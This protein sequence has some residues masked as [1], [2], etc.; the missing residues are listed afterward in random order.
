MTRRPL[1]VA[2]ALKLQPVQ[3][4]H[5]VVMPNRKKQAV[6]HVSKP[7]VKTSLEVRRT[8]FPKKQRQNFY[9]Q[10]PHF[11]GK[12]DAPVQTFLVKRLNGCES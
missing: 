6:P 9:E 3:L 4:F 10:L 5:H 2:K 11:D 1:E 12:K 8:R 7:F